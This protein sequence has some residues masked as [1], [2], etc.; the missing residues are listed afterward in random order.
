MN[1]TTIKG[2]LI[3]LALEGKFDIS[4]TDVTHFTPWELGS[5]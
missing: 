3:T 1:I 4:P 2:N 5:P